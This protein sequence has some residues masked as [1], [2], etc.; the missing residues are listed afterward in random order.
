MFCLQFYR[1]ICG[2][3]QQVY[4]ADFGLG[5]IMNKLKVGRTTMQAGTPA[6]QP[7]E[8]LKGEECGIKSDIYALGCR[9]F[10]WDCRVGKLAPS[11]HHTQGGR[12][13]VPLSFAPPNG[14]T[15]YNRFVFSP[16]G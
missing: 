14:S 9:S 7:P 16:T 1:N 11:Y 6:F 8:Q 4:L 10:W 13:I 12:W 5:K 2:L 15:E 3:P